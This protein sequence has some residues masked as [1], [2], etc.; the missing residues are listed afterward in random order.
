MTSGEPLE[1]VDLMRVAGQVR[2]REAEVCRTG[3]VAVPDLILR[4]A[5]RLLLCRRIT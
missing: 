2:Q 3:Q 5:Y 4:G 1:Q